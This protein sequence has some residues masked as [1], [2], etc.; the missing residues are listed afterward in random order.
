MEGEWRWKTGP[1][2]GQQFWQGAANGTSLTYSNW[3]LNEPDD[4]KNQWRPIGEDYG[5]F[6]GQ[7]GFWNDLGD[8]EPGISGYIVEYGGLEAC[9]PVLYSTATVTV[10][11]NR[12]A[13]SRIAPTGQA[14]V[15]TVLEAYPN[16]S[17]GQFRV[18]VVAGADSKT[19]LDLF[20]IS[21]RRISTLFDGAMQAGEQRE[22]SVNMPEIGAG[23]YT[24]RLQDSQGVQH[25]RVVIQK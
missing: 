12:P 19:Q 10:M 25:V 11:V 8:C 15:K 14:M 18:R 5:Q 24:V 9:T 4:F 3:S 20:D 1:E 16:P 7:S 6:Y 17:N 13:S 2:A 23:L 22:V 21:G